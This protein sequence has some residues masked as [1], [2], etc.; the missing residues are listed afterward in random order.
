VHAV[1][2]LLWSPWRRVAGLAAILRAAHHRSWF[3]FR[4]PA[5]TSWA[6]RLEQTSPFPA[7]IGLTRE[8]TLFPVNQTGTTQ[9][10]FEQ[11]KLVDYRTADWL[12]ERK[13]L[14]DFVVCSLL[15]MG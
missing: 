9:L 14:T 12:F 15:R 11:R 4:L 7:R 10:F 5:L 2:T 6:N 3:E 8:S 13:T 1:D